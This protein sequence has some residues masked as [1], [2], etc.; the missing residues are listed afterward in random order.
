MDR[1]LRA[2]ILGLV[3]FAAVGGGI[4]LVSAATA[5]PRDHQVLPAPRP[6]D[7]AVYQGIQI[8][9][10]PQSALMLRTTLSRVTYEWMPA[11]TSTDSGFGTHLVAPLRYEFV[12][13]EGTSY[14]SHY[15]RETDYDVATGEPVA[16]KMQGT[17]TSQ[18]SALLMGPSTVDHSYTLASY[19]GPLA[20]CG[21]RV[22]IQGSPL[23][24]GFS[25][26][27]FCGWPDGNDT[28]QFDP[29]GWQDAK[30]GSSFV[31]T[32]H[33][34]SHVTLAYDATSPFPVRIASS[35]ADAVYAP[36]TRGRMWFLDRESYTP[37]SG[38]YP[39]GFTATPSPL[40]PIPT[41]PRTP[42]GVRDEGVSVH[43]PLSKA[44]EAALAEQPSPTGSTTTTQFL[45]ANPDAYLAFAW[46]AEFVDRDAGHHYDW[47]LAF[48]DGRGVTELD[49]VV[50]L[51][52]LGTSGVYLPPQ[53]GEYVNVGDW[54][55][56][57]D[58]GNEGGTFPPAALVP[59]DFPD[60]ALLLDRYHTMTGQQGNRYGFDVSCSAACAHVELY[61]GA[62]YGLETLPDPAT[63]K[64]TNLG[65][66]AYQYSQIAVDERGGLRSWVME[67]GH[68][69]GTIP[70]N[71]PTTAAPVLAQ[72]ALG[73]RW[74]AP[75][76]PAAAGL[77]FLSLL[78]AGA[79]YF[80][81]SL[82]AALF[83]FSRIDEDELLQH[84][85]RRRI[86]D[87]VAAQPG[88]HFQE[89]GRQLALGR[90]A[91]EHHLRKLEAGNL[92]VRRRALGYVCFFPRMGTD[93]R[94]MAASPA[95][96]SAGSRAVFDAVAQRPGQSF[97][98]IAAHAGLATST[99]EHHLRRLAEAGL[100]E[101]AGGVRLTAD[102]QRQRGQAPGRP[103]V[104]AAAASA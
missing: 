64:V 84:P 54:Q 103:V 55:R 61:E 102:G 98:A 49:K 79:Y 30:G 56:S 11:T 34:D 3:T 14:E 67:E 35:L 46:F 60:A 47:F 31:Y 5:D 57:T 66:L 91:L 16:Y 15:T 50:R 104:V 10:D 37:G 32:A 45:A 51:E 4:G 33:G 86:V 89:L 29:V 9:L 69:D 101:I 65:S 25:E 92:L 94:D 2:A 82:R 23:A 53:S 42:W 17:Y 59:S 41:V 20:P 24:G 83:G 18:Q 70:A 88:I 73:A 38:T 97:R 90:G 74:F 96:K 39:S 100:V 76:A 22:P 43:F 1:L 28:T 95:L 99:A 21:M 8:V 63:S 52:P 85:Q 78:S 58:A 68:G 13:D 81:P 71:L 19:D 80:W 27:A 77:G 48:A 12:F 75:S 6:G 72:A 7:R 40:G 44:Y 87:L 26:R 93:R 62:A 36:Y